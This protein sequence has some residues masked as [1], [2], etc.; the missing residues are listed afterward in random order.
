MMNEYKVVKIIDDK[1][2]VINYGEDDGAKIGD[3]FQII[4]TGEE[5]IDP[6]TNISLGTLDTVKDIVQVVDVLPKMS[7]CKNRSTYMKNIMHGIMDS[8]VYDEVKDK[9]LNVD[10][11]QITGGLSKDITIRIGD[12]VRYLK[13]ENNN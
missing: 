9:T 13:N 1:T 2:I 8:L 4:S 11:S 10:I 12:K 7:I 3:K 6:D 5:I